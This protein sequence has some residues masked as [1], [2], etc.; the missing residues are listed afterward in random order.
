MAVY[1]GHRWFY[2][3]MRRFVEDVRANQPPAVTLEDALH[4]LQV[5]EAAYQRGAHRQTGCRAVRRAGRPGN[6]ELTSA[7]QCDS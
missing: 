6:L 7:P 2:E 5:I 4:V 3:I 1:G